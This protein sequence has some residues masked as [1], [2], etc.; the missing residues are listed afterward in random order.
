MSKSVGSFRRGKKIA[1]KV[2][3]TTPV[4]VWIQAGLASPGPPLGPQI[5][6]RGINI[7]QFCR[8]FNEKTAKLKQGIPIPCKISVNVSF[9]KTSN[10]K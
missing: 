5:G 9:S 7:A 10:L 3:H 1:E 2:I 8:E 6:Q 4:F